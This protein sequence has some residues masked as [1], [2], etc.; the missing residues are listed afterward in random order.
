MHNL[1]D[2]DNRQLILS[3]QLIQPLHHNIDQMQIQLAHKVND[4]NQRSPFEVVNLSVGDV[5]KPVMP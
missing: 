4:Q 3:F 5:K 2:H 1:F